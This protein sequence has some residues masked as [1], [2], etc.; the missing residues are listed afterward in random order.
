MSSIERDFCAAGV[1]GLSLVPPD[2]SDIGGEGGVRASEVAEASDFAAGGVEG[3]GE[4]SV[5]REA[6]DTDTAEAGDL[7]LVDSADTMRRLSNRPLLLVS[8]SRSFSCT[9]S[10]ST[11]SS[12]SSSFRRC[13][14]IRKASRSCSPALISSSSMTPRSIATLYFDSKSSNDDVVF[15]A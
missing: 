10:A 15:L 2:F 4:E 11:F 14:S 9:I 12:D 1:E 5:V 7:S 13:D 3:V 6:A 8:A